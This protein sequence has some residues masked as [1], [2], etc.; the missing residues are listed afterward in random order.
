MM[1]V[2]IL[3]MLWRKNPTTWMESDTQETSKRMRFQ[4]KVPKHQPRAVGE[5]PLESP[6][7]WWYQELR[8]SF[9]AGIRKLVNPKFPLHMLT[10]VPQQPTDLHG[11]W[12]SHAAALSGLLPLGSVILRVDSP[13]VVVVVVGSLMYQNDGISRSV[14]PGLLLE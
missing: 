6:R 14:L 7:L 10:T 1:E 11:C 3:D 2:H 9:C 13:V 12:R 8:C 5:L 4:H